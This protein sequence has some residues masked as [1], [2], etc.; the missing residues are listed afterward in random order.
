MQPIPASSQPLQFSQILHSNN[1]GQFGHF[2]HDRNTKRLCKNAK[3]LL[4]SQPDRKSYVQHRN[5]NRKHSNSNF[6]LHN[7]KSNIEAVGVHHQCVQFGQPM[8]VAVVYCAMRQRYVAVPGGLLASLARKS[9]A[10]P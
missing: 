8:Q 10:R 2:R 3:L 7:S 5:G 9:S 6:S 4:F 1:C